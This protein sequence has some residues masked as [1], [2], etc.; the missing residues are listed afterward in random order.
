[1]QHLSAVRLKSTIQQVFQNRA[2]STAFRESNAS[3]KRQAL[4][5]SEGSHQRS[6]LPGVLSKI[7]DGGR[8]QVHPVFR[9]TTRNE[10]SSS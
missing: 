6:E 1:M 8:G 4:D 9:A 10:P 5:L 7:R 3:R 2:G